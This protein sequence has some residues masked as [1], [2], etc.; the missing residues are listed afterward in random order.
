MEGNCIRVNKVY[1]LLCLVHNSSEYSISDCKP[2]FPGDA[3]SKPGESKGKNIPLLNH[4]H[5]VFSTRQTAGRPGNIQE[6]FLL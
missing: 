1:L 3:Q 5:L 2:G 4:F 6:R